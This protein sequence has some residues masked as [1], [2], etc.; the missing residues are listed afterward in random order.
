MRTARLCVT[1]TAP[2]MAELRARRDDVV[3]ADLVELRVDTVR[4]PDA[5]AALA[6]RKGPVI[7]TC[8]AA[9]EGGFFTGSEEERRRILQDAYR[10]GAD[11]VDVEWKS[12]FTDLLA[13]DNGRRLIVSA[14]DF[15][16][17]PADL[18][19]QYRA[20]RSTGAEVVK[21]AIMA[22]RLTDT[23]ALL[24]LRGTDDRPAV[25]L[26]MGE[27]GFASRVLAARFGSAWTY[28]GDG[29]APG[30]VPASTLRRRL[31]F[32]RATAEAP[33]YGVV[34]RPVMHSLSP[35]MHNAAFDAVGI[36]GIYLPLAAETFAD[37]LEFA[38]A[39]GL[40]GASVTAPFKLAAFEAAGE[41]DEV[42]RRIGSVNTLKRSAQGWAGCNTDGPGFLEPLARRR[43]VDG[44]RATVMGAGGA[45][46]GVADALRAAGAR[47]SVAARQPARATDVARAA[48]V[49]VAGWPPAAGTWDVLVNATPVGTWPDVRATPLPE[50]PFTGSLVYDLVYNPLETQFLADARA[51]G[52]ETL[53]GLEMLVAQAARQFEWWTGHKAPAHVMHEAAREALQSD[54]RSVAEPV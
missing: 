37:F 35:A 36:D 21:I 16:G 19:S 24:R 10:L 45:A 18:P 44:L 27:S 41:C 2:T 15:D 40:R 49:E 23:L 33:I 6:G 1:V 29:V 42:A 9:S 5:A 54:R 20:M 46:R 53:G 13:A 34:G 48:G 52:C 31:A 43:P 28:A 12:S 22:R 3:G 32:D 4:D 25:L 14:H 7:F 17:V 51:A 11:Y 47:V 38:D 50:G 30:Q 39:L 8:R 26:A